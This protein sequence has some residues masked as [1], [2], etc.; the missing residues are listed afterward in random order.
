MFLKA[1][2]NTNLGVFVWAILHGKYHCTGIIFCK[3][4]TMLS[5]VK[6]TRTL[7]GIV[8][9]LTTFTICILWLGCSLTFTNVSMTIHG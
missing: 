5:K 9:K 1:Q 7:G 6:F 3:S 2:F 8:I 4:P